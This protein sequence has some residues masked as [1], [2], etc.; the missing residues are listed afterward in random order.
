MALVSSKGRGRLDGQTTSSVGP[1]PLL[2]GVRCL[3]LYSRARWFRVCCIRTGGTPQVLPGLF[4]R[5]LRLYLLVRSFFLVTNVSG[6][7]LV[8]RHTPFRPQ[9]SYH[10]SLTVHPRIPDNPFDTPSR[11]PYHGVAIFLCV[12]CIL[13][14]TT[15]TFVNM[16]VRMCVPSPSDGSLHTKYC[17]RRPL[18]CPVCVVGKRKNKCITY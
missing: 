11:V 18:L 12:S 14:V 8:P 3:V 16:R 4:G 5:S 2:D 7:G 1:G 13:F 10:P 15:H 6:P 9:T 17:P